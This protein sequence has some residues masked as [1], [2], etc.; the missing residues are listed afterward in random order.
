MYKNGNFEDMRMFPE[1]CV[2]LNLIFSCT[3]QRYRGS[4]I[5][6]VGRSARAG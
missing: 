3:L 6:L 1:T 4:T 5:D 2:L